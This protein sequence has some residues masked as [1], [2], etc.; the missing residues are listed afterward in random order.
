MGRRHQLFIIGKVNGHYRPLCALHNQ[1]LYGQEALECCVD[2]LNFLE[3]PSNRMPIQQELMAAANKSDE[4]WPAQ[5][6]NFG[7]DSDEV[8]FPFI[9]TCLSLGATLGSDGDFRGTSVC[10]FYSTFDQGDNNDGTSASFSTGLTIFDITDLD[11]VRYRFVARDH[12]QKDFFPRFRLEPLPARTYW[13][14]YAHRLRRNEP[15]ESFPLLQLFQGR[16]LVTV[17]ALNG[18]W[19][20]RKWHEIS[21]ITGD[22]QQNHTKSPKHAASGSAAATNAGLSSGKQLTEP[23]ENTLPARM[24]SL[25]DQSMDNLLEL[26]LHSAHDNSGLVAEAEIFPDFLAKLRCRLYDNAATLQP[27]NPVIDLLHKALKEEAEVDISVFKEFA[28]SD[29]ALLV[30]KLRGGRMRVLNLS[31]MPELTEP[32]LHQIL[33]IHQLPS[34]MAEPEAKNSALATSSITD[35]RAIILLESPKISLEFL[36]EHLGHYDVYHSALFRRPMEREGT[37]AYFH[38]K[39]RLKVLQFGAA[40]IVSQ[41]VWVG[42]T[43]IQAGDSKLRLENGHCDWSSLKYS[44]EAYSHDVDQHTELK[45][46]N[47]LLDVPSPAAKIVRS[48]QRLTQYL[49]KVSGLEDWPKAAARCFATTSNLDDDGYS[50][51]PFSTTLYQERSHGRDLV[52]SGKNHAL[53]PGQ[54][55]IILVHEAFDAR[56][57]MIVDDYESKTINDA[58]EEPKT[59]P[60][61]KQEP[62][63]KSLKRL[64]YAFVKALSD[65]DPSKQHLLVTDLSGY[66]E[67]VTGG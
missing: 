56:L 13:G 55:A 48:L 3:N 45:Y 51:G 40:N 54:W 9:A 52:E 28:A 50:V 61:Q 47:F 66:V 62:K 39:E 19:P 26:L 34:A 41:L 24:K 7:K 46:K 10:Q 42:T 35:L 21:S 1:Y 29:L 12:E 37:I 36:S 44:A 8:P 5:T 14:V 23:W 22:E 67:D 16:G 53:M 65:L 31:N 58:T 60:V 4:F 32:D 2:I 38:R 20:H 57:R 27:T 64:R 49:S 6:R 17:G 30:A 18:T 25:R 59:C 63:P 43:T 15:D 11:H 33:D